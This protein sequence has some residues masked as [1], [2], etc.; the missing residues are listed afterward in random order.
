MRVT[1]PV[2]VKDEENLLFVGKKAEQ[3]RALSEADLLD[4]PKFF[5][6]TSGKKGQKSFILG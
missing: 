5:R 1:L 6:Y 3:G 4:K 2:S